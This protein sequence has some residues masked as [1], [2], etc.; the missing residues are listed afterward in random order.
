MFEI[1]LEEKLISA[2]IL[3]FFVS[4]IL[5][6]VF[7]GALYQ[8]MIQEAENMATT[9]HKLLKQWCAGDNRQG[10]QRRPDGLRTKA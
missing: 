5:M 4:S 7:L 3:V 9:N 1:F 10:R 2:G 6:R 8:N